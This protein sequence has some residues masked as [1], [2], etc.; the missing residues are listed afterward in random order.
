MPAFTVVLFQDPHQPEFWIGSVPAIRGVHSQGETRDEALQM[1]TLALEGTLELFF[2]LGKFIPSDMTNFDLALAQI[3]DD[4]GL[5]EGYFDVV[6]VDLSVRVT[7][8]SM[9]HSEVSAFATASG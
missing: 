4:Y 1:T 2:E 9:L 5:A 6:K 7:A 3:K 8:A